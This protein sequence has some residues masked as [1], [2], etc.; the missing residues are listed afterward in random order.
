MPKALI[1]VRFA[2]AITR[3]DPTGWNIPANLTGSPVSTPNGTM[4]WIWKSIT[5]STRTLCSR[6]SSSMSITAR[7]TPSISPISGA[8]PAIG[9]PSCPPKTWTSLSNCSSDASSSTNTPTRQL[10][11][12]ITFGVSAMSTTFR[13]AM[14]APSTEP[15]WTLKARVTRQKS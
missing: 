7:C 4:S 1:L 3:S 9:P 6:P 11:S 10:P 8:S 14:S 5:S 2:S 15:S 12:V 13:P